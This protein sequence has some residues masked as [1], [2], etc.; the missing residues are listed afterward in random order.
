[1]LDDLDLNGIQDERARALI[2][3]LLNLIEDLTADLRAAQEEIQH[4]RDE[5]NR[6]KGQQGQPE[7]KPNTPPPSPDHSSEHERRRR[8]ERVKRG[9]RATIT[10]NREEVARLDRASLPPDAKFQ[11]YEDVVVQDLLIRTDNVLFHKEVFYSPSQHKSYRA[12]LPRGY[13]G[14]FGPGVKALVLVL[15]FGCLMSE[16][17]IRELLVN[18]GIQIAEG[19]LSNLLI[20]DQETFHTEQAS[21]Y[22][23]GLRSSPWQ[24][25]DDTATRVN[26]VNQHCQIVCNP[27]H[28]HYQTTEA[29]DRL[30]ILDVLRGG[31]PRRFRLNAEA[32]GYLEQVQ[33]SQSTRERLLK[34]PWEQDLDEATLEQL[35]AQVLA[36]VGPHQR[37]WIRDAL[38]V[39]AYHA[40]TEWPL[41]RLL[42]GDDAPQWT[43]LTEELAGC[44]V[45]EGRHYKKLTPW[46]DAHRDALTDFLSQFWD[47]YA[48]LLVYRQQPSEAERVRLAAAFDSLFA[49][50]TDYWALN[51][52]ISK[53]RAKKEALLLVLSH[54]EIPLHNNAAELA[55]RQRVRKRDVSFG[56][57]TAEGAKA[58][59]T[60][61]SLADTTRKLGVSFYHYIHDRIRGEQQVPPLADQIDERAQELN[62]GASWATT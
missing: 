28:T 12:P 1:M 43:W 6:L 25:I 48:E 31:A 17:K 56:P 24:Q 46:L 40:Q 30:T 52:R 34:L 13:A 33:L 61:M 32:L 39:A 55:A 2:V 4:L 59:D 42:V 49:T 44:W 10:I 19:T 22:A 16:A 23:A 20:K 54:P 14:A 8:T 26:G 9:K 45:H 15:Y 60:F 41:I 7:I 11:G 53:T 29:K 50:T 47:F 18:V 21:V 27:L 38:A 62:L 51:D 3:R 35:M 36:D 58:W 57:R 5:N 37:K